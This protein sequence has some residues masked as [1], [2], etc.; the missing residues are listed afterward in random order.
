[1]M[2]ELVTSRVSCFQHVAVS[3]QYFETV[4]RYDKFFSQEPG[5]L[6]DVLMAFLD[7]RGLRS[8]SAQVCSRTAYLFSRFIK[9]INK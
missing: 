8:Q 6:A 3:L 7:E 5:M 4:V 9:S 2:S 1:M